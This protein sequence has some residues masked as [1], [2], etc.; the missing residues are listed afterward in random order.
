[1]YCY[2][3]IDH[4]TGESKKSEMISFYNMTKGALKVVDEMAAL[5]IPQ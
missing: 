5:Y 1:M 4:M 2:D 3:A